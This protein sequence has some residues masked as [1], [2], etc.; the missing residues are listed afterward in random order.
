[1]DSVDEILDV[2]CVAELT[3]SPG[4]TLTTKKIL[5]QNGMLG[6]ELKGYLASKNLSP[7]ILDKGMYDRL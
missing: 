3:T 2:A 4:L 5:G 6:L 1:L 7:Q